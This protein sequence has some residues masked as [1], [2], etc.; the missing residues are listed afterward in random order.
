MNRFLLAAILSQS[1]VTPAFAINRILPPSMPSGDDGSENL[2]EKPDPKCE[3]ASAKVPARLQGKETM[4]MAM[5]VRFLKSLHQS[6]TQGGDGMD[7]SMKPLLSMMPTEIQP[8][9]AALSAGMPE[10]MMKASL[11]TVPAE[12]RALVILMGFMAFY[13]SVPDAQLW[14]SDKLIEILRTYVPAKSFYELVRQRLSI[15]AMAPNQLEASHIAAFV[16]IGT[17]ALGLDL[18]DAA[19]N[20]D[21]FGLAERMQFLVTEN[22]QPRAFMLSMAAIGDPVFFDEAKEALRKLCS[23]KSDA[24]L[25]DKASKNLCGWSDEEPLLQSI[26]NYQTTRPEILEFRD[27]FKAALRKGNEVLAEFIEMVARKPIL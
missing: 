5:V 27:Q 18:Q 15:F 7:P 2:P 4:A 20:L 12:R 24:E 8:D 19:L 25:L 11:N 13:N 22:I 17:E 23:A 10:G 3:T 6:H 26:Y 16:R 9:L 21:L 14:L 1:L